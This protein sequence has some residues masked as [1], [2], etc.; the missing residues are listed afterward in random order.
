MS[1]A[2][3][4]IFVYGTLRGDINALMYHI[5]ARYT[6]FVDDGYFTGKLFEV[7]NYPGAIITN[8]KNE[9][10]YGEIYRIKK[11][12]TDLVLKELDEYEECTDEFPEP[13]AYRRTKIKVVVPRLNKELFAWA[14]IFNHPTDNLEPIPSGDYFTY[15]NEKKR[16]F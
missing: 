9:K 16:I 10:V 3:E 11:N 13:P 1:K 15:L 4:Y 8:N 7:D 12:V 2:E 14:Y 5:I 6:D